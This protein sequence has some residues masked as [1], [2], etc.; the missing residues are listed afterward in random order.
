MLQKIVEHDTKDPPSTIN[1]TFNP[2]MYAHNYLGYFMLDIGISSLVRF[3][4]RFLF[5]ISYF[6]VI[7]KKIYK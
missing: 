1:E 7:Y 6:C 5:K 2:Y 3:V 4:V